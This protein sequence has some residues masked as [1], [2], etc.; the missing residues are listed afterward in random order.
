M[1][2]LRQ[3]GGL[4]GQALLL[5]FAAHALLLLTHHALL[6]LSLLALEVGEP[7]LLGQP[8]RAARG[9]LSTTDR[10]QGAAGNTRAKEHSSKQLQ[11]QH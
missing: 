3:A 8:A 4:R 7:L 10:M 1:Q 6:L 11:Q 5:G 9:T 2:H